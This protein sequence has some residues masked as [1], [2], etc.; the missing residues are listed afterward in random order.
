MV[1]CAQPMHSAQP[2]SYIKDLYF[3]FW[4]LFFQ[5]AQV[6][7]FNFQDLSALATLVDSLGMAWEC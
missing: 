1:V 3:S 6:P 7:V 4:F 5:S 2:S